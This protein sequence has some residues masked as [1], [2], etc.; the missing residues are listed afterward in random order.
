MVPK[1]IQ[2]QV[3]SNFSRK[4]NE[5]IRRRIIKFKLVIDYLDTVL[6]YL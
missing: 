6:G 2:K 1:L 4:K 3:Q 5:Q